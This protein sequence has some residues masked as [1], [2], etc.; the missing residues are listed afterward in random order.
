MTEP[1]WMALDF[2]LLELFPVSF[3]PH[4]ATTLWR[5][6]TRPER[7]LAGQRFDILN[8]VIFH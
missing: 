1:V 8:D 2:R 4:G 3:L 6:F 7:I 5:T